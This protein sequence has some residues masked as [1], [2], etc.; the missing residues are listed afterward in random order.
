MQ[1][2]MVQVIFIMGGLKNKAT[3]SLDHTQV[4]EMLMGHLFIQVFVQL[5]L[6]LKDQVLQVV[7][8]TCMT[9]KEIHLIL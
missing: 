4:M 9:L 1:M 6:L 2:E 5:G 7:I 3:A 8:G